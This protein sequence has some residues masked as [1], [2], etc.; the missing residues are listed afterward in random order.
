M[1]WQPQHE[2][3]S[4]EKPRCICPAC[5]TIDPPTEPAYGCPEC[6][7]GE[8]LSAL[9]G[10][11]PEVCPWCGDG[12]LELVTDDACAECRQ[13]EVEER[14]IYPCPYCGDIR[15]SKYEYHLCPAR[16]RAEPVVPAQAWTEGNGTKVAYLR[17]EC[18]AREEQVKVNGRLCPGWR[19]IVEDFHAG[20]RDAFR[21][22]V[23]CSYSWGRNPGR[24]E[25][26]G[27]EP[28]PYQ[29]KLP[30]ERR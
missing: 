27:T 23:F 17:L 24:L 20:D 4:L 1:W 3:L 16:P 11:I 6:G 18:K 19:K 28:Y 29:R 7:M 26:T 10:E 30:L 9:G 14:E 2:Q 25:G 15:L 13:G 21:R 22:C 8:T 5:R 12:K